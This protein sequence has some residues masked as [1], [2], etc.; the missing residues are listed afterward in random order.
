MTGIVHTIATMST[1]NAGKDI[2]ML[3]VMV[4]L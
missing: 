4:L 3:T 1:I 2:R